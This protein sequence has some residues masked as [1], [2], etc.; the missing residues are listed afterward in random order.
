MTPRFDEDMPLP[1]RRLRRT[2]WV[3]EYRSISG[4]WIPSI[5]FPAYR[6]RSAARARMQEMNNKAGVLFYRMVRYEACL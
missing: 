3:L 2:V 1:P 4:K 6:K 5:D